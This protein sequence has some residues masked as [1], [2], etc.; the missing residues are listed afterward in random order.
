MFKWISLNKF[1]KSVFYES[2]M[3]AFFFWVTLFLLI[4]V[5]IWFTL[6]I[7]QHSD[8]LDKVNSMDFRNARL[9]KSR[10]LLFIKKQKTKK[11]NVCTPKCALRNLL[12]S[13]WTKFTSVGISEVSSFGKKKGKIRFEFAL[14]IGGGR[15]KV[16]ALQ[17]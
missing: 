17:L 8:C 15:G 16:G 2:L 1:C 13:K 7:S 14:F 3:I 5:A 4:Y 11:T 12:V 10:S 9:N 6:V